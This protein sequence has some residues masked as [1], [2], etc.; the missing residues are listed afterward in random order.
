MF[1]ILSACVFDLLPV[2]WP[3]PVGFGILDTSALNSVWIIG[4]LTFAYKSCISV[5]GVYFAQPEQKSKIKRMVQGA[6][7]ACE[8]ATL[9]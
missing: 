2:S 1:N 8:L 3:D 6:S 4:F 5:D 7:R 9:S